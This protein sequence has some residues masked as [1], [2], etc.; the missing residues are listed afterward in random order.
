M[1][2]L[3]PRI[4]PRASAQCAAK[5]STQHSATPRSVSSASERT[6]VTHSVALHLGR[7]PKHLPLPQS[8][9]QR[10]LLPTSSPPQSLRRWRSTLHLL[11]RP[12]RQP[13]PFPIDLGESVAPT[14]VLCGCVCEVPGVFFSS[15]LALQLSARRLHLSPHS[16]TCFVE[17]TLP[18]ARCLRCSPSPLKRLCS[19]EHT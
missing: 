1:L 17:L 12:R 2:P 16:D 7:A 4:A 10:L 13:P 11:P 18:T 5:Q 8:H 3:P 19:R 9:L 6:T 14:N 15:H